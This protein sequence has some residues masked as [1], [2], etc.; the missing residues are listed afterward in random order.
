MHFGRAKRFSDRMA[1]R[2]TFPILFVKDTAGYGIPIETSGPASCNFAH[3]I[4]VA[5]LDGPQLLNS[6]RNQPYWISSRDRD[7]LEVAVKSMIE[8]SRVR[9]GRLLLFAGA[10]LCMLRCAQGQPT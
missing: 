7:A 8:K 3:F 2:S 5:M 10:M 1:R 6:C 4:L 9:A